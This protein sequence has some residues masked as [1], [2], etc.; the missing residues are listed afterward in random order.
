[1]VTTVCFVDDVLKAFKECFRVL[2]NSGT[3]L[4][5]FVD[6]ESTIGKIYQANKRKK[7]IL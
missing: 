5:G 4:I 7:S 3:I 2:K 6:R 1:M